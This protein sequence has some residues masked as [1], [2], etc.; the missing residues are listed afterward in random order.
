MSLNIL[1][2][3]EVYSHR[4]L[5]TGSDLRNVTKLEEPFPFGQTDIERHGVSGLELP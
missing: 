5:L 1:S 4:G 2:L 3:T